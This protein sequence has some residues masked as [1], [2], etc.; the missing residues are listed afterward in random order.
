E[1][2]VNGIVT[3]SFPADGKRSVKGSAVVDVARGSWIAARCTARDDLLTDEELAAYANGDKQ[4]P[5]RLRFAHTSPLYV[6]VGGKRTA[7]R[8]SLEEGRRLIDRFEAFARKTA[9][10]QYQTGMT[11]A[12]AQARKTLEGRFADAEP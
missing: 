3:A 7:A 5:S 4:Q 10:P 2:V 1:L 9:A 8:A 6:T 12:I 11:D